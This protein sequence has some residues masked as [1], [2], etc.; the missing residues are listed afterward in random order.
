[1]RCT[2]PAPTTNHA[3][4]P[5]AHA[6]A[7]N[8]NPAVVWAKVAATMHTV[9]HNAAAAKMSSLGLISTR[10]L[11]HGVITGVSATTARALASCA[12]P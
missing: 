5:G 8:A 7:A 6:A 11:S 2:M 4:S 9:T 12:I 10:R 1:M 3:I